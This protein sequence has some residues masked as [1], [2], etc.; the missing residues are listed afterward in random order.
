MVR[1]TTHVSSGFVSEGNI[2]HRVDELAAVLY[3]PRV[4]YDLSD[5][6]VLAVDVH[7][8]V[9]QSRGIS[10]SSTPQPTQVTLY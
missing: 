3:R 2:N 8:V 5:H 1:A 4:V 7:G 6:G 9:F 10:R